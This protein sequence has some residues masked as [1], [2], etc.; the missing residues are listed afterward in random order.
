MGWDTSD[1]ILAEYELV[2]ILDLLHTQITFICLWYTDYLIIPP[3]L[4]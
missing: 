2:E 1:I 4:K 3:V